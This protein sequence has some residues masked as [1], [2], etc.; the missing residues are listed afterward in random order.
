MVV[1][2]TGVRVRRGTHAAGGRGDGDGRQRHVAAG[3]RRLC[4]VGQ[5]QRLLRGLGD[6][7]VGRAGWWLEPR[8]LPNGDLDARRSG[9]HLLRRQVVFSGLR[10]ARIFSISASCATRWSWIWSAVCSTASASSKVA[11]ARLSLAAASTFWPTM[12]MLSSTSWR[13][14]WLIHETMR[15]GFPDVIAAGSE[16]SASAAKA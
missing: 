7:L 14:V 16:M 9:L 5:P 1:E 12:M 3:P 2:R 4:R 10:P 6:E 8:R 13:N 11:S 15:T